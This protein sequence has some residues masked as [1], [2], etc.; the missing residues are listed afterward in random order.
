MESVKIYDR[1]DTENIPHGADRYIIDDYFNSL[2]H[3]R[4]NIYGVSFEESFKTKEQAIEYYHEL[5]KKGFK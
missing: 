4:S 3:V 2:Y 1:R 5:G